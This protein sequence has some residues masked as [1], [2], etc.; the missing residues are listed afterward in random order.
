[1]AFDHQK[2]QSIPSAGSALGGTGPRVLPEE[3]KQVRYAD[4]RFTALIL[5]LRP[6]SSS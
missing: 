5:P 3:E 2:F 6:C 1:V 4:C